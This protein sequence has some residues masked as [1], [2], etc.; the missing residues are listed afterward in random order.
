MRQKTQFATGTCFPLMAGGEQASPLD[1][2]IADNSAGTAVLP[3]LAAH[4]DAMPS[5]R[6]ISV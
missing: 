2:H 6:V 4:S 1:L 3:M 5:C